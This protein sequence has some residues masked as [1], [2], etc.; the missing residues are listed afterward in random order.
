[1]FFM[2]L[3]SGEALMSSCNYIRER[4]LIQGVSSVV[5]PELLEVD[6]TAHMIQQ[7]SAAF[8]VAT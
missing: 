2:S 8:R 4:W 7:D 6:F 1:M 5:F 3:F